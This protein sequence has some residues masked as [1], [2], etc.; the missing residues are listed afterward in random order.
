MCSSDLD[1][2][3]Y[4][5]VAGVAFVAVMGGALYILTRTGKLEEEEDEALDPMITGE[6]GGIGYG[7]LNVVGGILA[8]PFVLYNQLLRLLDALSN[9]GDSPPEES[10]S[11]EPAGDKKAAKPSG[12]GD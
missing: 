7:A 1:P 8:V 2:F 10:T 11:I 12:S 3:V 9:A 6:R 5:I 4:A